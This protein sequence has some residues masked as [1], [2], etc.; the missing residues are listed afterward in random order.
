[1]DR[2]LGFQEDGA[3]RISRQTAH[4]GVKDV[5]PTHRPL[6]SPPPRG[7][8]LGALRLNSLSLKMAW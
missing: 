4:E 1:L 5:S 3:T 6:V 8:I 7:T 2:P